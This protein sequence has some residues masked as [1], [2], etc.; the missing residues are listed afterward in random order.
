MNRARLVPSCGLSRAVT[1]TAWCTKSCE[2][3][4]EGKDAAAAATNAANSTMQ[5]TEKGG[6]NT[7]VKA[8]K[9]SQRTHQHSDSQCSCR[10]HD[11]CGRAR[12]C[13]DCSDW[14]IQTGSD[15]LT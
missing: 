2:A 3:Q 5:A 4:K 9:G 15:S 1:P 6:K 14:V 10:A 12:A 13:F 8:R 11:K 7:N